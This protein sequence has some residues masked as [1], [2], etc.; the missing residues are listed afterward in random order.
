MQHLS[1]RHESVR[2]TTESVQTITDDR[3]LYCGKMNSNLM[4][5]AGPRTNL[6]KITLREAL[7]QLKMRQR[8]P[9]LYITRRPANR[10]LL[11]VWNA[12]DGKINTAQCF[13]EMPFYK[14]EIGLLYFT[15]L[16]KALQLDKSFLC[17]CNHEDSRCFLIK[18]VDNT[19]PEQCP[20][21]LGNLWIM[22]ESPAH[23]RSIAGSDRMSQETGRLIDEKDR[24][25][26]E[27][28][29]RIDAR[30]RSKFGFSR[31]RGPFQRN[32]VVHQHFFIWFR[33]YLT[34]MHDLSTAYQL[35]NHSTRKALRTVLL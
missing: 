27:Q 1:W 31:K 8:G 25:V 6:N 20:T 5:S 29:V 2:F 13:R 18:T 19:G 7:Q 16:K 33:G 15:F 23:Q 34:V 32:H 26:F 35:R 24:F 9:R 4:G 28:D 21:Y 14:G 3:V 30:F 22:S 10:T 12:S 11:A 17:F